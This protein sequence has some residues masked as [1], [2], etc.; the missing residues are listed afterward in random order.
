MSINAA[1]Q[2][3]QAREMIAK[4]QGAGLRVPFLAGAELRMAD[5]LADQPV[6]RDVLLARA[7]AK[8]GD[9]GEGDLDFEWFLAAQG[10]DERLFRARAI[11]K[12]LDGAGWLSPEP[13]L[14]RL[15]GLEYAGT[16][17]TRYR[18]HVTHTLLVYV[19]GAYLV[20]CCSPLRAAVGY[21]TE[22]EGRDA[23][24]VE[25]IAWWRRTSLFHDIGYLFENESAEACRDAVGLVREYPKLLLRRL[26]SPRPGLTPLTD[27]RWNAL[28]LDVER[29]MPPVREV[30][31]LFTATDPS[32]SP[33]SAFDILDESGE[34]PAVLRANGGFRNYFDLCRTTALGRRQ[35]YLDHGIMSALVLLKIGELARRFLAVVGERIAPLK[36]SEWDGFLA[37]ARDELAEECR[38]LAECAAS[39]AVHN[40]SPHIHGD[41]AT[42]TLQGVDRLPKH[43]CVDLRKNPS[44]FLLR[45]SD[46]LQDWN[47]RYFRSPLAEEEELPR[48]R[49]AQDVDIHATSDKIVV[50]VTAAGDKAKRD[51]W[52]SLDDLVIGDD[53]KLV[54]PLAAGSDHSASDWFAVEFRSPIPP[55]IVRSKENLPADAVGEALRTGRAALAKRIGTF[56]QR[57]AALIHVKD[58]APG[59]GVPPAELDLTAALGEMYEAGMELG[60]ARQALWELVSSLLHESG[61]SVEEWEFQ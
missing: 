31:D 34:T 38:E 55:T 4:L 2:L 44:A 58:Q 52:E 36:L 56:K 23:R 59:A 14:R 46:G 10:P 51:F 33:R 60:P 40:I 30:Y 32:G 45:L 42:E 39:I 57:I 7:P 21:D 50:R 6:V 53:R 25:F 1:V 47:R 12:K 29:A 41:G 20:R 37:R 11:L 28:K 43:Y 61:F 3:K 22:P 16:F 54:P 9:P 19:L 8:G 17:H 24:Y 48:P 18:D 15:S 5:F 27:E 13:F 26:A 49:G 35:P